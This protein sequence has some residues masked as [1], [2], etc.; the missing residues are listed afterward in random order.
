MRRRS[1]LEY[2]A[3]PVL[4]W[5]FDES[6][7]ATAA[8]DSSPSGFTGVYRGESVLPTPSLLV[9]PTGF[10]NPRSLAFGPSGRPGIQLVTASPH[11]VRPAPSP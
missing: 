2:G 11:C 4:Y 8:T 3:G 6:S 1:V 5:R 9:P 7:G 10:A